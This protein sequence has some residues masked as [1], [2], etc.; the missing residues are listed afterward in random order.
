LYVISEGGIIKMCG[1]RLEATVLCTVENFFGGEV[2]EQLMKS[3]GLKP[4]GSFCGGFLDESECG[5][6]KGPI[7]DTAAEFP[8]GGKGIHLLKIKIPDCGTNPRTGICIIC[9]CRAARRRP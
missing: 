2:I 8:V 6:E 9:Y 4:S 1:Y 3:T 7:A 5:R